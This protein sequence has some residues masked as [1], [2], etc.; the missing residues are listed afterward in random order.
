MQDSKWVG[1]QGSLDYQGSD[2]T[3]S[4]TIAN[5]DLLDGSVVSVVQYLQSMTPQWV[6]YEFMKHCYIHLSQ[7]RYIESPSNR[8][9]HSTVCAKRLHS[10]YDCLAQ[11]KACPDS[12]IGCDM[13][14]EWALW[15]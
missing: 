12:L 8:W 6:H 11:R 7:P 5:P 9:F 1:Y 13:C 14:A 4:V 10:N 2:F 15:V 3:A